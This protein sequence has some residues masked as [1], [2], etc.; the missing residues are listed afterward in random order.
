MAQ[1]YRIKVAPLKDGWSGWVGDGKSST[2]R[3]FDTKEEANAWAEKERARIKTVDHGE[4]VPAEILRERLKK[5]GITQVAAAKLC[6]ISPNTIANY[7]TGRSIV[8]M[9]TVKALFRSGWDTQ[10]TNE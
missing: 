6:G 10:E 2:S 3:R 1:I 5:I 9:G 4:I 7:I 8:R